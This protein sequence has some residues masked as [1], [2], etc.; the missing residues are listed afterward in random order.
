M[1]IK[2]RTHEIARDFDVPSKEIIEL[3]KNSLGVERRYMTILGNS[4]L[5]Y[6]FE[7]YTQRDS[8]EN[9]DGYFSGR[10]VNVP[11]AENLNEIINLYKSKFVSDKNIPEE[12]SNKKQDL[13]PVNLDNEVV[14]KFADKTNDNKKSFIQNRDK[15]ANSFTE[16]A[17]QKPQKSGPKNNRQKNVLNLNSSGITKPNGEVKLI[18]ESEVQSSEN[19]KIKIINIKDSN[20]NI[21]KYDEKYD[22]MANSKNINITKKIDNLVT[23]QKIHQKLRRNQYKKV[24]KKRESEFERLARIAKQRKE[25]PIT[26]LIPEFISV[27]ELAIRLKASVNEVIKKLI[28]LGIM[29][30]INESLDFDTASLVALEFNAKIQFEVKKT[31]EE[32]ALD[33]TADKYED[34]IPR[35]PVVVVMGHVDHGKT[36]ILDKIRSSSVAMSEHGGITQHIG[37]YKVE[38]DNRS[39]TF[40]DTPG[41]A[42]FTAMRARGSQ[43]TDIAILVVAADDGVMPQTVESISHAKDAG[44]SVILAINKID[45][46]GANSDKIKQQI[47]EHGLVPEEWGGDVPCVEVSAKTG[48]GIKELLDMILLVSDLKEFKANPN[49]VANGSVIEARLDKGRGAIAT[50]IIENGVL[51][52]GDFIVAGSKMGHVRHIMS[53]KG[54]KIKHA[55]PSDP[56]EIMGLNG[57]PVGGDK[58]NVVAD[59]KL[60]KQLVEQRKFT[61]DVERLSSNDKITLENLFEHMKE[62]NNIELKL[63]IKADVNGSLEA[64]KHALEKISVTDSD[65]DGKNIKMIKV[66]IVFGAVGA[67]SDSDV[68]LAQASHATIIGFNVRLSPN[69]AEMAKVNSVEVKIYRVIYDCVNDITS[70]LNGLVSTKTREIELGVAECR[71]VYKITN[72][73]M[74]VGCYVTSGKLQRG[75]NVQ[76]VRDG[77]IIF[78]DKIDSIRRFKDDVKEVNQGYECGI[79]LSKFSDIKTHDEFR[80][81]KLEEY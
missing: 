52:Q 36:S 57:V 72:I 56:V 24:S 8:A 46:P 69:A 53:D 41:H 81:Y 55:Y 20:V 66:K 68:M 6:I 34:L 31:I 44:V 45:K 54:A 38:I 49:R 40:L 15:F 65:A 14:S 12:N 47:S 17:S 4:E 21:S 58:F 63:I 62:S 35:P 10:K 28:N 39:I 78:D 67:I 80:A 29:A 79:K 7:F 75:A 32:L 48:A 77:V 5:D 23:K 11:N 76:V 42:A 16:I 37:A 1:A 43:V 74:V 30:T 22:V 26:V 51:N 33:V 19:G 59:E 25:K 60:A 9:F 64:V 3:L 50:L 13:E 61:T 27:A 70:A 71:K 2:Y 73:G 18:Q